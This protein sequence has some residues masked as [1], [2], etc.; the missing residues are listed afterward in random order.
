MTNESLPG[1]GYGPQ[2]PGAAL[3]RNLSPTGQLIR[4]AIY[5]RVS[6]PQ[7]AITGFG[8]SA[9]KTLLPE[10]CERVGWRIVGE[11]EEPGISADSLLQRPQFLRLLEDAKAGQF[12]VILA[13]EETRFSRGD[14]TDWGYIV[15]V[16]DG[17]GVK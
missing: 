2:A 16:C 14:M 12:D 4:V 1:N 13:I 6:D 10:Y 3:D 17:A 15:S 9:Q 11:Y 5:Y 8:Y 7:Q